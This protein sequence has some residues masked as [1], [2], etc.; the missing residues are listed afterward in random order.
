M[1]VADAG[2]FAVRGEG[3]V[4]QR[5]VL[6]GVVAAAVQREVPVLQ[7]KS[8]EGAPYVQDLV[9]IGV[10]YKARAIDETAD[11]VLN[12]AGLKRQVEQPEEPIAEPASESDAISPPKR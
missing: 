10:V 6:L 11:L 5:L 9:N 1:L 3:R 8:A 12:A 7:T 2:T 4:G